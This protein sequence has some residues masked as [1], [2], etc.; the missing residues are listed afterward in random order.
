MPIVQS[1]EIPIITYHS[2]DHSGSVISTAPD[3]FRRQMRVLHEQGYRILG[4]NKLLGLLSEG[5]S[6][7]AK[8]AV[9]TFDDGFQNFYTEVFPVLEEYEFGATVFLVTDFCGKYN[10]WKG[11][12][13]KLPLSRLLSWKQIRELK[14]HGIEFGSHTRT[15]PDLTRTPA[16]KLENEIAGSKKMIEDA[17]G[18][19]VATFA[20]PYGKFNLSVKRIVENSF[21]AACSTDLGKIKTGS[22]YFS[23]ERIDAFYLAN[24]RIFRSLSTRGFDRYLAVRRLMRDVK[25]KVLTN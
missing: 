8:T 6:L 1:I 3:V 14:K 11:N 18:S 16:E 20:Y 4:L 12:P 21:D 2:V 24:P 9:I 22:D 25:A 17:L 19:E 10:D 23:L 13:P 5:S 15:H 7:P